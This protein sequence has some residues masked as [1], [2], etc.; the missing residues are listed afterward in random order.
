V[1]TEVGIDVEIEI[2]KALSNLN[3][4]LSGVKKIE[5]VGKKSIGEGI[6]KPF[7]NAETAIASARRQ[8]FTF[9]ASARR[10]GEGGKKSA[11]HV[12]AAYNKLSNE[13]NRSD[14][15]AKQARRAM[16]A[17]KDSMATGRISAADFRK[18]LVDKNK[19][20]KTSV[21]TAK[22]AR[23][24]MGA[25]KD[26]MVA[27]RT[28]AVDLR[29]ALADKNKALKTAVKG[30]EKLGKTVRKNQTI[31]TKMSSVMAAY[32]GP[33]GPIAGR[34]RSLGTAI[35]QTGLGMVGFIAAAVAMADGLRRLIIFSVRTA[36][37]FE[38]MFQT[39][40]FASDGLTDFASNSAFV[41]STTR[42]LGINL[43]A[44]VSGF[45]KLS[46]AT[47]GTAL[48]GKE[49]RKV[50]L[51][52]SSAAATLRL[53]AAD[54][55]GV[56]RALTQ[57]I[58]KGKVSAE[59]LRGQLGERLPGAFKIASDAMGVT[60]AE[61]SKMLE[62]GE[63]ITEDFLPRFSAAMQEHFAGG[64]ESA[65]DTASAAIE[66]LRTNINL[67]GER[68]GDKLLEF[69]LP[70][71]KNLNDIVR[72]LNEI[73]G[74]EGTIKSQLAKLDAPI[75]VP[76]DIEDAPR[77]VIAAYKKMERAKRRVLKDQLTKN[78]KVSVPAGINLEAATS[79]Y[80]KRFKK[81]K[82]IRDEEDKEFL[83]T[84]AM[85]IRG[86]KAIGAR[87]EIEQEVADSV[88]ARMN[89]E[90][91]NEDRLADK[92]DTAI[93]NIKK[94][95]RA[96]E[97]GNN[98]LSKYTDAIKKLNEEK[99]YLTEE[100]YLNQLFKI[101]N[102]YED[103]VNPI[104]EASDK[105]KS[106]WQDAMEGMKDSTSDAI[107]DAIMQFRSLGDVVNSVSNMIAKTI[108]KQNISDPL[109]GSITSA[110]KGFSF[111]TSD[112]PAVGTLG[113]G[114]SRY[115]DSSPKERAAGGPVASG[116][117]YLVGEKGPELFSPKSSGNITPNN[118]LDGGGE[119]I[120]VTYS[121]Q[122][123]AF[124]ARSASQAI[125]SQAGE[126]LKIVEQAMNRRGRRGPLMA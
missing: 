27:G 68:L 37:K 85:I 47:K 78:G 35:N 125:K 65:A 30:Q 62:T 52:V 9:A 33:L 91:R 49:T 14:V 8:A 94:R 116:S 73:I 87:Q 45:A 67:L 31:F 83:G 117:T 121:P 88:A 29:K 106:A 13:L 99:P 60:T 102:A 119:T 115:Y 69:N 19:A 82:K 55:D 81:F 32:Q 44:S 63:V 72:A 38:A 123:T 86:N 53:S 79:L 57:M 118:K 7:K 74:A 28:S 15:T 11:T 80:E 42:K 22:Q 4:L 100:A 120:N 124:D 105:A 24:S 109:A 96:T 126:V 122:V 70:A 77:K 90:M 50:F 113:G 101:Q 34:I 84:E 95:A 108:I 59:E 16:D 43:E 26:S 40:K 56:M 89:A 64:A 61:L 18:A 12:I 114:V 93:E 66:R 23:R 5:A 39:L 1:A 17:F 51:A 21:N 2:G 112:T 41:I 110:L 111:G 97:L 107:T 25:F 104:E 3:K 10:I 75:I 6:D 46:A 76:E 48:Q 54:T 92:A 36:I 71:I 98:A 58:S 103:M 20:L